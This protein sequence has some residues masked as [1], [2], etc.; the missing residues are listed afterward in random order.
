MVLFY[1]KYY[2]PCIL[3]GYFINSSEWVLC[4][5]EMVN[6]QVISDTLMI[7]IIVPFIVC[8]KTLYYCVYRLCERV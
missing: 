6:M 3:I 2:L 8:V 5:I 4:V 1:L 7:C